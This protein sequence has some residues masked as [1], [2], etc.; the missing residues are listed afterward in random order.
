MRKQTE[1][2]CHE[3]SLPDSTGN[4]PRSAP[5]FLHVEDTE[6]IGDSKD[7][8]R[9]GGQRRRRKGR[10]ADVH[11]SGT[12]RHFLNRWNQTSVPGR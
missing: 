12:Q 10:K 3:N 8:V 11:L 7:R 5:Q 2:G 4:Q 6:V 9:K 1:E